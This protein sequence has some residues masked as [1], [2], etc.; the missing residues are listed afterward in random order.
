MDDSIDNLWS[1]LYATGYLTRKG[2]GQEEEDV[3]ELA[4]PNKEIKKL[5]VDLVKDWF[6]ETTLAD[7]EK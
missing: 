3:L 5:F 4:I 7:S 2:S 6:Q 1:V